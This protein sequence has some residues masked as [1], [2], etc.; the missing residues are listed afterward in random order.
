MPVVSPH[1]QLVTATYLSSTAFGA[2][3]GTWGSAVPRVRDQAGLD[4]GQLGTALLFISAGALPAMLLT[5][6]ALDRW[7]LR[8]TALLVVALGGAGLAAGVTAHG[9]PSL[10][11]G[12]VAVGIASGAADVAMNSVGGRAEQRS[13]RPIITR[14]GAVFSTAVVASSLGTGAAFAHGAP[15]WVPF[16]GVLLLSVL[17]GA[18]IHR[19]LPRHVSAPEPGVPAGGTGSRLP[20]VP[21]LLVGVLGA[22]AFA[23]EN[24]HQSWGAV[25]MADVLAAGP[26]L[27]ATA[28][29]AFAAV[30]AATRFAVSTLPPKYA[31]PVLV[32]GAVVA[33]GGAALLAHAPTVPVALAGLVLAAAGTAALF[34]TLLSIVSRNV[35]ESARGRATSI[36]TVVSYL[37]FLLGPVYVGL[38]ASGTGL[39]G[40]MVA[41]AALGLA[42]AALTLPLLALSRYAVTP[43]PPARHAESVAVPSTHSP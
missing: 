41:V 40:A 31:R 7:G 35:V 11:A 1:R 19:A 26:G 24:A 28:P 3:W 2:F 12:L 5:G 10:C 27:S 21:L 32:L 20:V 14:A 9:F 23:S 25:F 16:A 22:L 42:L 18:G 36:V 37:G 6:R 30:V 33:A 4:A 17:A 15:T 38:W 43:R 39:R 34:P 13:G 29:A 8:P